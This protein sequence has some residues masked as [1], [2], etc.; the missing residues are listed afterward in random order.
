MS[1]ATGGYDGGNAQ[2]GQGY[3]Q[4]PG[5]YQPPQPPPG[6][7]AGPP[8]PGGGYG[9]APWNAPSPQGAPGASEKGFFGALF[10]LSFKSFVTL[11]FAKVIYVIAIVVVGVLWLFATIVGFLDSPGAGLAA[12]LLGWIPA[13]VY[14]V[15]IRVSLEFAVAMVRTA[16]NTSVLT[17]R[18]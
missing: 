11:S 14:I 4:T 1:Q 8:P 16:Q 10:D 5:P 6:P 12:L 7:P 3:G 17:Y 9:A 2:G 15:L 18:R 13:L